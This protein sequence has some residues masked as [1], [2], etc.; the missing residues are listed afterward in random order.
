MNDIS[1]TALLTLKCHIQDAQQIES[2]LNDSSALKTY[3]NPQIR[4][5]I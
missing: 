5:R 2:I 4:V 1:N 3:Q